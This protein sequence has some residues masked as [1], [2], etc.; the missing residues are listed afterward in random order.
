M[1]VDDLLPADGPHAGPGMETEI[2][3]VTLAGEGGV[4]AMTM[5][6]NHCCAQPAI[7]VRVFTS[8]DGTTWA[9]AGLP[10]D[11]FVT[12]A[13]TDGDVAVLGGYLERGASAVF[14]V[15]ER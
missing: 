5:G 3:Q 8:T 7:G 14:W 9:E 11:A 2:N 1:N 15:T 12:A 6:W 10:G 4:L 13:A